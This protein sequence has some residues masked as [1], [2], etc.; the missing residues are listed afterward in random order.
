VQWQD[1]ADV[2]RRAYISPGAF[3]EGLQ[4]TV[5]WLG[6]GLVALGLAGVAVRAAQ[7]VTRWRF[8]SADLLVGVLVAFV[9]GYGNKEAG[10]FPKA[11]GR[12]HRDR[13]SGRADGRLVAGNRLVPATGGVSDRLLVRHDGHPRS[14]RLGRRQP[15]PGPDLCRRK[16]GRD[17]CG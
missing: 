15:G 7:I 9:L 13:W 8:G 10:W 6:P 11:R 17:P 12:C 3:I 14:G 5:L 16:R 1:S 4:P 2:A